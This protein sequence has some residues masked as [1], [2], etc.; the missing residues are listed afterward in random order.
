MRNLLAF[1]TKYYHWLIFL[2]L[3]VASGVMLFKFNSYQGSV[4]ISTANVVAGQV[5]SWRASLEQFFSLTRVNEEL[6]LRNFYLERQVSQLRRLYGD[7]TQDTTQTEHQLKRGE[8]LMP[9]CVEPDGSL[10]MVG[11]GDWCAGFYPGVLWQMYQ[12]TRNPFW[13][14]QAATNTWLMEAVKNDGSSHDLGFMMYCSFGKAYELTGQKEYRDVVVQAARTLASRFDEKVGC[15]RSWSW[16]GDRWSF[17][18]MG[19]ARKFSSIFFHSS[20]G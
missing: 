6:T 17:P 15:I 10:R 7:M 3:E 5:Y 2:L 11:R 9:R 12:L 20:I 4:W 13:C 19:R 8:Q 16:G 1:L 14:E 18:V